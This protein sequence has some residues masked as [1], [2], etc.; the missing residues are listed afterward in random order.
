MIPDCATVQKGAYILFLH[1]H[2]PIATTVGALGKSRF[3]AG[4]YL[5][6]GSA[7]RGIEQRVTRHLRLAESKSG[8]I[9][10]H[11]DYLLTHPQ[12][13]LVRIQKL[14]GCN[15]CRVSRE[16]SSMKGVTI[17]VQRFGSTDCRAGCTAHLYRMQS[18]T[19]LKTLLKENLIF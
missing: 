1:V 15:E 9:H 14:E 12:V 4:R 16:I 2:Q 7:S 5:Y 11:I 19:A 18:W 8:N 13:K 10:W 17:P 3:P 6:V